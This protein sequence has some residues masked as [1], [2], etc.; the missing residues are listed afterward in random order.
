M[1]SVVISEKGGAER[2]EVFDSS[3]VTV[4]RVRGNDLVLPKGNV[5][6][7]HARLTQKDGRFVVVDQNST[8]GT[9]VNRQRIVQAT[10]VREGD[11][12]Y[13]GD[14]IL[15]IDGAPG[16]Q[17]NGAAPLARPE[18]ETLERDSWVGPS[19]EDLKAAQVPPAPRVPAG[20]TGR[21][22]LHAVPEAV[23]PPRPSKTESVHRDPTPVE[24]IRALV[25]RVA[26]KVER[27]TLE[28]D[29][30]ESTSRRIE[31]C[32]VEELGR[33]RLELGV[34][35]QL[36]EEQLLAL[37][38]AELIGLGPLEILIHG[39]SVVQLTANG[40]VSANSVREGGSSMAEIPFS[41]AESVDRVL[42][43]L[44]RQSDVSHDGRET[45]LN[46]RLPGGVV[47][48]VVRQRACPDG[49][50][51]VLRRQ[52]A[53]RGSLETLVREGTVSRAMATFLGHCLSAGAN[54]L[55]TGGEASSVARVLSALAA[56]VDGRQLL[57]LEERYRLAVDVES[58]VR[59][60]ATTATV[61]PVRMLDFASALPKACLVVENLLGRCLAPTIE[62]V[63]RGVGGVVAGAYAPSVERALSRL[64]SHFAVQCPGVTVEAGR[65]SIAANLDVVV[66]VFSPG[67][68]RDR[69]RRLVELV[70]DPSGQTQLKEIFSFV[71]E[72]TAA[73]GA[74]EGA[75][76]ATGVEPALARELRA[77]GVALDASLFSRPSAG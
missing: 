25:E 31:R 41:C 4:G 33:L 38:R 2:R 69:V 55:V 47:W 1:F 30:G 27:R 73:G 52:A 5:S 53:V 46:G 58:A 29:I 7:R 42:A 26:E 67:D 13:I 9:Y 20:V 77:R 75:F 76:H 48:R 70:E 54:L 28:R 17:S 32:L 68:G 3:E 24:S 23:E 34:S 71:V 56:G 19:P 10:I 18:G 6:K 8:N 14:F 72:R 50:V 22:P 57:V 43:R 21:S 36:P 65:R 49:I 60:D 61:D 74:V 59:L 11:R 16:S 51:F 35:S 12:I 39:E 44:C 40:T 45:F 63:G 37:A 15:R 64:A 66:E 62:A